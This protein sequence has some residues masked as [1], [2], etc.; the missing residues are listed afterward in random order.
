M[1]RPAAL[2]L[3]LYHDG[4]ATNDSPSYCTRP[5]CS[6]PV[7]VVQVMMRAGFPF[8]PVLPPRDDNILL[9]PS[10][11]DDQQT[12]TRETST[13]T[14]TTKPSFVPCAKTHHACLARA[15]ASQGFGARRRASCLIPVGSDGNY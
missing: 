5:W 13:D 6:D 11:A 7:V 3:C 12:D 10:T 8:L 1:T 9:T 14:V 2:V 4:C 15:P